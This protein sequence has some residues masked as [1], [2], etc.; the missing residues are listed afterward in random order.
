MLYLIRMSQSQNQ[1]LRAWEERVVS[2]ERGSRIVHYT[3]RDSTTNSLLAVV[4]IE[5]SRN[6]MIYS[7]TEDYL[8]VFGSTEAVHSG[9]KWKARKDVVEFLM[10]IT[11]VGGPIF[12][13]SSM[14][15]SYRIFNGLIF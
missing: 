4:G 12:A 14:L 2:K 10:S 8:R 3:L 11:S 1:V 15:C 13:I 7:V 6:H 5:K 9:T